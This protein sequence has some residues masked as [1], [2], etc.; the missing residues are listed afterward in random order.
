M[1]DG[2]NIFTYVST[3][4]KYKINYFKKQYLKHAKISGN[5]VEIHKTNEFLNKL[6]EEIRSILYQKFRHTI[7]TYSIFHGITSFMAKIPNNK[8][9]QILPFDIINYAIEV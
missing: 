7:G 2:T 8:K 6:E 1:N 4:S 5:C 9:A 3:K